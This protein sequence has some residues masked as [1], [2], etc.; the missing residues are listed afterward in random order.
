MRSTATSFVRM[1]SNALLHHVPTS[2]WRAVFPKTEL[3]FCY[4]LVSDAAVPHV[5]HYPVL[6]MAEFQTDLAYLR[7]NFDF[8]SYEQLA[9]RRGSRG[10]VRDNAGV[11]T[12]DD[13][14]AE[15]ASIVAPA[16]L[17]HGI[18]C[19]FFVI[20]DLIDNG[21]V[22]RETE[23]SLCI[24]AILRSPLERVE[25]SV[26]EIGLDARLS[27]PPVRALFDTARD[28]LTVAGLDRLP[29]PRLRPLLHWLLTMEAADVDLMRRLSE[30][31]GVDAEAYVRTARP[32]LTTAQ[33]RQLQA[34]GFTIGAH[35]LSHRWLQ[36]LSK[37]EAA[38]EIVESCRVIRDIT[39]QK[40]VPFAFP[41]FGGGIDRD[42]LAELRQAHDFIGLYFD[43]DGLRED[44]PFVVQRVFGERFGSDRTMDAI[45]RRAW[46]RR[47]A[48][49]RN[50]WV[51][52]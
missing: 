3:G 6:S 41:Y 50:G 48:W 24:D 52:A 1:A 4:H 46:A 7:N 9:R 37:A 8:I 45:L 11:L 29:E 19:V 21:T 51:R 13:G 28:P 39:G 14:F 22:F 17:R 40:Q 49:K 42:W 47:P 38:H 12:F 31:L 34:D 30:Q 16:L 20:A 43:S 23:A 44:A 5:R 32:Y 27:C 25:A 10:P 33:I 15:C 35:G 26:R 36:S 18:D 2:C